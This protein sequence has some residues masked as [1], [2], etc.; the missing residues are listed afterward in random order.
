MPSVWSYEVREY[1]SARDQT[2]SVVAWA[3]D[4]FVARDAFNWYVKERGKDSHRRFTFT[5]G[6]QMI[7]Q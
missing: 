7:D 4:R 3:E 6:D 1:K 2:G 5:R